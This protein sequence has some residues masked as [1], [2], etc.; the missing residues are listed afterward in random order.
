MKAFS[1]GQQVWIRRFGSKGE[2]EAPMNCGGVVVRLCMSHRAAWV[3]LHQRYP[4]LEDKFPFPA[5][6]ERGCN[7]M[8]WPED[9]EPM[10][11]RRIQSPDV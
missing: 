10:R 2:H 3:K 11:G 1:L 7:V 4:S 6:D 8:A 9:C 5:D